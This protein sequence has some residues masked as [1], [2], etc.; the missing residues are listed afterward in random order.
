MNNKKLAKFLSLNANSI[1]Y[2]LKISFG[3]FFL[4]PVIG[5]LYFAIRYDL[6]NRNDAA[7]YLLAFLVFS[8]LGFAIVRQIMQG[9]G[10]VANAMTEE[11]TDR[12][13]HDASAR[14]ELEEIADSFKVLSQQLRQTGDS[15]NLRMNEIEA[16]GDLNHLASALVD[17]KTLLSRALERSVQ[18]TQATGGAIF[19]LEK[20]GPTTLLTCRSNVGTGILFEPGR[21]SPLA[22]HPVRKAVETDDALLLSRSED[23][24]WD[25][26]FSED[27]RHLAAIPF[28]R[29]R[30]FI[31]VAVLG[32]SG[33]EPW[34]EEI[35]GFL[36][37]FFNVVGT[38]LKVNELGLRE[39]EREEDLRTVLAI[40]KMIN[41]GLNE[42]EMLMA[43]ADKLNDVIAHHWIGLALIDE[44]SGDLKLAHT[45][46]KTTPKIPI[47]LTLPPNRSL[48]HTAM[49]SREVLSLEDIAQGPKHI[50]RV[51]LEKLGL[52]SCL[53]SAMTFKGT[54][55]G[56]ICLAHAE[57][58]AF[59]KK[60][61]RIL[62]MIS[63]E[64]S[65]AIAQARLLTR[66]Q[67]KSGELELLNRVGKALT[68]STFNMQKVLTYTVEMISGLMNV[69]AGSLLLVEGDELVFKVALGKAGESVKSF[70]IKL[71]QGIAG[72]V[73]ATGEPMLVKDVKDDPHFFS[74]MDDK[75]G[76]KTRNLVCV[77]MI[78]SGRTIGVIELI[79]KVA[80]TFTDEDLR[81]LKAVASSAA[82]ALE[83]SR[84]YSDSIN[85]AKR[86]RLIRN[87]FRKY[88]PEEV[89]HEILSRGERDLITLGEKR[90]VT[91]LNADIRGYSH[92]AKQVKAEDVVGVLNY[93]FMTMGTLVLKNKGILDKYLGDGLLAIFGAPVTTRN[94]ALDATLAAIHMAQNMEKVNTYA[95][96]RCG[97]PLKVGVSINT[98]E[99]IVGNVGFEKKMD[100]TAIGDVVND[101]FRLQELTREKPNSILISKSTFEKVEPFVHAESLGVKMLGKNEGE[102]E[103]FEITGKREMSDMEYLMYQS[104]LKEQSDGENQ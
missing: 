41:S 60:H 46:R 38:A 33:D 22:E 51:I 57:K 4:V 31:G 27:I 80:G 28:N 54:P 10:K 7:Y 76:F 102:M 55:I 49:R 70:R 13:D 67:A 90:L 30:G 43:I 92:M 78:V 36:K 75:T 2:R 64:M 53:L 77:P 66:A 104:K 47:G 97:I 52:T 40:I 87:I 48:F 69:E 26:L 73:A 1:I 94:P 9:I 29:S 42:K 91:L 11:V 72:W 8:F 82:I 98:G 95:Q 61:G 21:A 96:K 103:V 19:T 88:V 50:E 81:M 85:I 20:R 84:L 83:N 63:E 23:S 56:A 5:F 65:L 100:Y 79:N 58:G 14:D 62:K 59:H 32:K 101:T 39:R 17:K 74:G 6:L 45:F 86:E 25:D 24:R 44:N 93:F 18:V 3:F 35:L 99:A 37:P 15:L 89:S 68:S 71:G 16:L 34:R 12:L